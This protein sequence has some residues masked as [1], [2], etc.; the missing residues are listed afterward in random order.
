MKLHKRKTQ[1]ITKSVKLYPSIANMIEGDRNDLVFKGL[2]KLADISVGSEVRFQLEDEC[3]V[4]N[5]KKR[6]LH[7][8]TT[9]SK[10]SKMI[11]I[12]PP[13]VEKSIVFIRRFTS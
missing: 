6:V 7:Y 2:E 9:G 12:L 8:I 13:M 11:L 10:G 3:F 4:V 5:I 1:E